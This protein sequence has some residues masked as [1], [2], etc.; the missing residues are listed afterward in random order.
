MPVSDGW[1]EHTRGPGSTSP[2]HLLRLRSG[3]QGNGNSLK[4]APR[5]LSVPCVSTPG[6]GKCPVSC[7]GRTGLPF[8]TGFPPLPPRG[9][10]P[11]VALAADPR[12]TSPTQS[13]THRFRLCRAGSSRSSQRSPARP[14]SAA[15]VSVSLLACRACP[16]H[17]PV[18]TTATCKPVTRASASA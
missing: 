3:A 2:G 12:G 18:C 5:C 15:G 10:A 11:S 16:R 14:P 13:T 1:T 17:T 6:A 8:F 9:P 4:R 7:G